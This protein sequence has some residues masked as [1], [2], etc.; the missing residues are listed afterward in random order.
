MNFD[1]PH[2]IPP[3]FWRFW[4][5]HNRS[6]HVHS[7]R[8]HIYDVDSSD[9]RE[10]TSVSEFG[11]VRS[12]F[13]DFSCVASSNSRAAYD[14][15]E[16]AFLVLQ[17]QAEEA[18]QK[19]VDVIYPSSADT[20]VSTTRIPITPDDLSTIIKFF[21]FLRFRNSP[22][23]RELLKELLEP[24]DFQLSAKKSTSHVHP[25]GSK[26][27]MVLSVYSPLIRQVRIQTVLDTFCKFFQTPV[28]DM[29]LYNYSQDLPVPPEHS[30]PYPFKTVAN[31]HAHTSWSIR[32]DSCL[33]ALNRHCWQ[34]CRETEI[35]LGVA[36][37]EDREFI[38]PECCFGVLD[39]SFGGGVA[40]SESFDCF[41]PIL[42]TLA[43]YI[44]RNEDNHVRE[45]IPPFVQVGNELELD[46][47]LRNAMVLSSV[48]L[49]RRSEVFIHHR[50]LKTPVLEL[51]QIIWKESESSD[52]GDTKDPAASDIL[53][54][55]ATEIDTVSAT[56]DSP[57]SD[58][59]GVHNNNGT[60][61][62]SGPKIFFSSL[63]SIVQSISSYNQFRCNYIDYSRL[64]QQCR[65]KFSFDRMKK[66]WILKRDIVL[67]DLTDE[68]EVV[69]QHAVAFG[70]FSDV[71]MGKW[72][73][74][75]ERKQRMVAIKYLR[76]VMVQGVREK[77]LKRLQAELLTWHQLCHRNLAMLYGIVQTSTSIGMVSAWCDNGTI[78]SY[79]KKKPEADRL[80]LVASGVA[81]LH[82]FKPPVIHG[83][84]K[85]GNIL[86]DGHGKAVITDFGLSKV[87]EDL[88]NLSR[89][90][91]DDEGSK[92]RSTSSSFFAGSTRWMAPELV[93]AL[94]EDDDDDDDDRLKSGGRSEERE[95]AAGRAGGER[96]APR[97]TTASDVYA[98]ASVCL[99]IVTGS[100]PYPHRKNDYSVTVDILR[101]VL[102]SRGS[103][104]SGALGRMFVSKAPAASPEMLGNV[105]TFRGVLES[106]WDGD[107]MMRPSME[108]V[109]RYLNGIEEG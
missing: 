66:M 7:P 15:A 89:S 57:H 52:S 3:F 22:H 33:G 55:L 19:L 86:V 91:N 46:I 101:G 30:P 105:E 104:L 85:G 62:L 107:P 27:S 109:V 5:G 94:V 37:E 73:D 67:S 77:L 103:D 41:F 16:R 64:K 25:P 9:L 84:L 38:L 59:D 14:K 78:S 98:F 58:G 99:E 13:H 10:K 106:C 28:W 70:A 35:Y 8:L 69:G 97:V 45:A 108:D 76:Q 63:S 44:L 54:Q 81:Y 2:Y 42:P 68:V 60:P 29:R 40:E 79:L 47:H 93:L 50:D 56:V 21:V 102:P 36:V 71:W 49:G 65:Q 26:G 39:E 92:P 53:Q 74:I 34:Y 75:V 88:A 51:D 95:A 43:L 82:H 24:K 72:F 96:S 32:R 20:H 4:L 80:G 48:P 6:D 11:P 31:N 87:V 61:E 23:Y 100:L 18:L 12:M 90:A 17:S 83:D 1:V